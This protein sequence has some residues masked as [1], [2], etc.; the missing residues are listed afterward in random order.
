MDF[1]A[2]GGRAAFLHFQDTLSLV[3][4]IASTW[5]ERKAK[6]GRNGSRFGDFA[7][8]EFLRYAR[9]YDFGKGR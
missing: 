7:T 9:N 4:I 5:A 1:V 8:D 2:F 6:D 3:A